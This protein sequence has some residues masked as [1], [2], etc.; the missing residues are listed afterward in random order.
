MNVFTVSMGVNDENDFY[1]H[2]Q[3]SVNGGGG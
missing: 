2:K 1:I 3:S